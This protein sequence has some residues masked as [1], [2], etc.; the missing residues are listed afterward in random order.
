MNTFRADLSDDRPPIWRRPLALVGAAGGVLAIALLIAFI[1]TWRWAFHDMPRLP[2]DDETLWSTRLERS[3][4]LLGASGETLAVR[5]PLYGDVVRLNELPEH[6]PQAFIAIEDQRFYEHSGVDLQG[7]ARAFMANLRAGATVQGGSTLTMQLVKNLILTPERT[8]QRKIQEIRLA[9]ALERRLSKAEILELYLNR[10]YLGEQAYGVEAA[11][12]RYFNRPASE[13]TLQQAALLAALPKAPSRLAPTTN[14]DAARERAEDVLQAMLNAGHIDSINYITAT[15]Q[16]A[17]PDAPEGPD[18]ALYGH[19]FDYAIAIAEARL[20][21]SV[22]TPDL[23]IAT[24][25]EPRLQRAAMRAAEAHLGA[26]ADPRETALVAI[27]TDGRVRAMLGGLD[28][29]ESQFNRAVQARRQPGSAFKPV[30]F[31]AALEAGYE[32]SS[33]F[34]DEPIDLEGWS[35]ENFGGSYRGAITIADALKRSINT[36]AA[37]AGAAVGADRVAEMAQRLGVQS[38]IPALPAIALGAAE[39][40]LLEMTGVYLVFAND[41]LRRDVRL[42]ERITNR[43]GDVLW[44]AEPGPSARAVSVQDAQAMSTMLQSVVRDGTGTRAQLDRAAAGKTGTSQNSRDA[45][46]VG[47]TADYAAGVWV[48]R[49]DDQPMSGVTGGGLAA[50]IWHDF[51][52]MTHGDLPA[53]ALSAPP[54]R[55]RT[56]REERLAAF[57][58]ELSER[59]SEINADPSR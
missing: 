26:E 34:E 52:T 18:P 19:V 40:N 7:L 35:P 2:E 38:Q 12:R 45:W 39:V 10:V 1:V 11:A 15:A 30:V 44:R 22:E 47:F 58:S 43:R 14:L 28:Y 54:P 48:G 29:R 56:A 25:I 9:R 16:P 3:V 31:A 17:T 8:L 41:G 5:G 32:P 4:T 13:L 23:V 46:Y 6:V 49:D 50:M 21:E 37:Q 20:G 51:M 36:V 53:R 42:V 57:Y 27:D 33:T 24:S 59:F 55:R